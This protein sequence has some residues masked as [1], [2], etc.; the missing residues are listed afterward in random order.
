MIIDQT[1]FLFINQFA[2][3]NFYIDILFYFF[4]IIVPYLF[5]LFLGFFFLRNIKNYGWLTVEALFAGFFARY[6]LVEIVRYFVPR[7]R[8]F[9]ILEE[10]KLLLPYKETMSFPS[11]HTAFLFGIS[12][13][14][15]LYNKKIG[16][17][18]YAISSMAAMARVFMGIHW[19]VDVFV[20]ALVG[21]VT[22][23]FVSEIGSVI[24]KNLTKK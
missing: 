20:G 5:I 21:V 23:L 1:L 7:S 24:K 4:S 14:I 17:F 11:G 6:A 2:E 15:Y 8:P 3:Q 22:G 18:L 9:L 16:A 19:P 12:T 13:V 10:A